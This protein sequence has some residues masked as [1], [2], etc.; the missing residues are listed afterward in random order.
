MNTY[1]LNKANNDNL[2]VFFAGWS[3][4]YN[5]FLNLDTTNNDVLMIYDYNEIETPQIFNELDNYKCKTLITWSMGV[6]VGFLLKDLFIDFDKKIAINGTITPV[7][8]EFGIPRKMF[9]LTLKHSKKGL[10][11]KFYQNIF[12]TEEE[13]KK[14]ETC[15]VQRSIENRVSELENLYSLIK[16]KNGIDYEKFYD[17]ALVSEFD[18]I[19]PPK[20]Q[21]ASHNKN[22]VPTVILPYGHS[23]FFNFSSWDEIANANK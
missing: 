18:K 17:F 10:E 12:K 22:S 2:I 23:P 9:E 11:G 5:P 21:L 3:F 13:Y 14:Y 8:D 7:D 16:I 1:W 19:I 20:N 15:Q 6:F 4:D